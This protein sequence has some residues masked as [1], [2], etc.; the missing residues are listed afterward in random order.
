MKAY[1]IIA[2]I[3]V[4]FISGYLLHKP[5]DKVVTNVVTKI[6]Y[7]DRIV[8]KDTVI[9][10]K[11]YVAT[12]GTTITEE[13]EIIKDRIVEKEV[14]REKEVEKQ[15]PVNKDWILAI[16]YTHINHETDIQGLIVSRRVLGDL[17]IGIGA[18]IRMDMFAEDYMPKYNWQNI[19][20]NLSYTF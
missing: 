19:S 12:N 10:R 1:W 2:L 9:E 18:Y 7:K 3:I 6:E 16:N 5:K 14:I 17:Y 4:A 13:K 8:N 15:V 20:V 11:I